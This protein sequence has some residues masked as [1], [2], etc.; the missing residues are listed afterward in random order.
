MS[1][2]QDNYFFPTPQEI[3]SSPR[4]N[5]L[6]VH[7]FSSPSDFYIIPYVPP[8]YK[9]KQKP[10]PTHKAKSVAR[11]V[12]TEHSRTGVNCKDGEEW[13]QVDNNLAMLDWNASQSSHYEAVDASPLPTEPDPELAEAFRG[14]PE[15]ETPERYQFG[16]QSLDEG[17]PDMAM[18]RLLS[19]T[20]RDFPHVVEGDA[21]EEHYSATGVKPSN[22]TNSQEGGQTTSTGNEEHI[23]VQHSELDPDEVRTLFTKKIE[24]VQLNSPLAQDELLFSDVDATERPSTTRKRTYSEALDVM[25]ELEPEDTRSAKRRPANRRAESLILYPVSTSEPTLLRTPSG[26]GSRSRASNEPSP[27]PLG[28]DSK[29]DAAGIPDQLPHD[30][31]EENHD[32]SANIRG[33]VKELLRFPTHSASPFEETEDEQDIDPSLDRRRKKKKN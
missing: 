12:T 26:P 1:V 5:G 25:P 22:V 32:D 2:R 13:L 8:A 20:N 29:G 21:A 30:L 24:S 18:I 17:Q 10:K 33:T 27:G 3:T 7:L 15:L 14:A 23:V 16:R 31:L 6:L 4:Q 11:I 28:S 19:G 9:P